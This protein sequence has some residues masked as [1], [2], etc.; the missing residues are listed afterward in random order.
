MARNR[1][2]GEV[3]DKEGER[4]KILYCPFDRTGNVARPYAEDPLWETVS[5]DI[6][7]G[8]DVLTWNYKLDY[9]QR[10]KSQYFIPRV[11]IIAPISCTD[12]AIS[13]AKHFKAK[14]A[15]GRTA[16]SQKLVDWLRDFIKYFK[17]LDVLDFWQVENPMT[18]IHTIK[19]K[20]GNL[21]NAWL[22]QPTQKFN[23]CDFALCAP[24]PELDRYNK[25]TWLFGD[26]KQM[27]LNR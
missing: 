25:M 13:G 16:E 10:C 14:D 2:V 8:I 21:L 24:N 27:I 19:D 11:G 4:M 22:G 3:D 9:A 18:R 7:N 15:D 20:D 5:I 17:D 12:Y 26:F 1:D 23:P 6:Q